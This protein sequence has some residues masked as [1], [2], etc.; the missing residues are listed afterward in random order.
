VRCDFETPS[1]CR[2]LVDAH[3]PAVVLHLAWSSEPGR[4]LD[5]ERHL[6]HLAGSMALL[7]G[8]ART[9]CRR[10]VVAGS[11]VEYEGDQKPVGES[12]PVGPRTLYGA[13]KASLGLVGGRLAQRHGWGFCQARVFNVYGP[14]EDPR[15]L[16]PHV[17]LCLLRGAPCDLTAGS[18]VRDYLHVEDVASALV[19]LAASDVEGPVNVGSSEPVTVAALA[20]TI[21]SML[22]RPGLLR[23][24]SRP[25]RTADDS[26]LYADTRRLRERTGWEPR[27]SLEAGLRQTIAWWEDALSAGEGSVDAGGWARPT[28]AR[29]ADRLGRVGGER[30]RSSF[31]AAGRGHGSGRKPSSAPSRSWKWADGRSYGTS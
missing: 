22:G 8:V 20:R 4:W 11:S 18:Q 1:A 24:G 17:I 30:C 2:D 14:G 10:V 29:R 19:M 31:S 15:R 6:D 16:V 3:T 5:S 28:N 23:L 26:C 21:A 13:C 12:S 25:P 7:Q 9:G 27:Y